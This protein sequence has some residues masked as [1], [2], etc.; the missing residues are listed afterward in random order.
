MR[1]SVVSHDSCFDL[2]DD[3]PLVIES[4]V[5]VQHTYAEQPNRR[6]EYASRVAR[7]DTPKHCEAANH[8][9]MAVFIS[10]DCCGRHFCRNAGDI[11]GEERMI[12]GQST[13]NDAE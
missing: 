9:S 6:C 8:R 12:R 4:I 7:A 11:L 13:V 2:I 1:R 10:P 5:R 3:K